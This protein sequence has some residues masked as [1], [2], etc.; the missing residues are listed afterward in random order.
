MS[1]SPVLGSP[2]AVALFQA[3]VEDDVVSDSF[4]WIQGGNERDSRN[5]ALLIVTHSNGKT[6]IN[7]CPKTAA[8]RFQ[9]ERGLPV[10]LAL[11]PFTP[12]S[13]IVKREN[14]LRAVEITSI[15]ANDYSTSVHSLTKIDIPRA[16]ALTAPL[17]DRVSWTVSELALANPRCRFAVTGESFMCLDQHGIP[18]DIDLLDPTTHPDLPTVF[19]NTTCH[20]V[21]LIDEDQPQFADCRQISWIGRSPR[22]LIRPRTPSSEE[23]QRRELMS[24]LDRH[25]QETLCHAVCSIDP[26]VLLPQ[27]LFIF[28]RGGLVVE[29]G[30]CQECMETMIEDA[31]RAFF[32]RANGT[33][34][35]TQLR[36]LSQGLGPMPTVDSEIDATTGEAWPSVPLGALLWALC[37]SRR[38]APL[39]K[40]WVTGTVDIKLDDT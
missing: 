29:M 24:R 21:F 32:D 3:Y 39:V 5:E 20:L 19:G 10:V 37:S 14:P 4:A 23:A 1:A 25:G 16:Y 13:V 9:M 7:F 30:L 38:V 2:F 35:D 11:V 28:E 31:V 17:L 36:D 12:R 34:D 26:P 18:Q 6:Q 15:G 22:P 40:A 27:P 33:M 8:A